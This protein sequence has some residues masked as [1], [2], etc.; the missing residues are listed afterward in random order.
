VN[1]VPS[2]GITSSSLGR[3]ISG[4]YFIGVGIRQERQLEWLFIY[5]NKAGNCFANNEEVLN[6]KIPVTSLIK[7]L[8]L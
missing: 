6:I 7:Q 3:I 4:T 1:K 2:K 5:I 8:S